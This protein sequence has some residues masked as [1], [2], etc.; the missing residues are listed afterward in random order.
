M[1][2]DARGYIEIRYIKGNVLYCEINDKILLG[3]R[4]RVHRLQETG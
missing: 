1:F 2:N 4:E 3:T